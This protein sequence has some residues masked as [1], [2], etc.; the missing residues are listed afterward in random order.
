MGVGKEVNNLELSHDDISL[1][2]KNI[3][4]PTC[5]AIVSLAMSEA[6]RDEPDIR[7]LAAAIEQDVGMAALTIKLANSPMFRTSQPVSGVSVALAR[8][9]IRNVVC[10]VVAAALRSCMTGVDAKWLESFWNHASLVATAAGLIARKQ[11]GIP[12]D[13]AY[14][15]ALFHDAAIPLLRKRF[16]NYCEVIKQAMERRQP[17]I[18]A[19]NEYFPCT[20]PIV[21]SL[22]ARNWGLPKNI[23]QSIL[24]HHESNV[25]QLPEATLAGASVSL[26]AVT[27]VAERLIAELNENANFEVSDE[28]YQEALHHLSITIEELEEIRELLEHESSRV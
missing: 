9:G 18:D 21:G 26:I 27:H 11:H 23:G 6:Q 4:I 3:D 5:P 12:P 15:F 24:F 17:L 7:K 20:H 22:L 16:D 2:F 14:T 8:L 25:Y 10:V 19:E 1:V 13:A 28:H